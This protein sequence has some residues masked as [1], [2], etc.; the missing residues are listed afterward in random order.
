MSIGGIGGTGKSFTNLLTCIPLNRFEVHLGLM[1]SQG[2]LMKDIPEGVHIH[3]LPPLSNVETVR[4]MLKSFHWTD[5]LSFILSWLY[6][7]ITHNDYWLCYNKYRKAPCLDDRFDLAIAFRSIP[8]E[9]IWYLCHKIQAEKKCI[10]VHEDLSM[11][12]E[13]LKYRMVGKLHQSID[14][15]VAV[16][17]AA[18]SRF[19][20]AFPQMRQKTIVI[21]NIIPVEEVLE[22]ARNGNTFR[23]T[24]QGHRLLTVG[25]LHPT[26]GLLMAIHTLRIL[27]DKHID[28]KWYIIGGKVGNKYYRQCMKL[29]R[30]ERVTDHLAFLDEQENPYRFMKDCDIYVQPSLY[31]SFCITLGEALCFG[32]PIVC[33]DFCG[34]AQMRGR[35]N[36]YITDFTP[37]AI[38][39]G[40]EQALK[41][42]KIQVSPNQ[43]SPDVNRLHEFLS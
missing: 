13:R 11:P 10:W 23:D 9:F 4:S 1:E 26:K 30:Q 42:E 41:A 15:I 36:G 38:A 18:K 20:E 7:R 22:K 24:Y 37:E 2:A 16:S 39:K 17:E 28:V 40:I 35:P 34:V 21:H 12:Q 19:D 14:S 5:A 25:R 8:G 43:Q 33:T 31:E 6:S 27:L 3:T 32:N 29:A